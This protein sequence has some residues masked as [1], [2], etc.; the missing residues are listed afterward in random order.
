MLG[1]AKPGRRF[2]TFPQPCARLSLNQRILHFSLLDDTCSIL[3][4]M[5]PPKITS[6]LVAK[7]AIRVATRIVTLT[8]WSEGWGFFLRFFV[9]R[10][11]LSIFL[12]IASYSI[13]MVL[14]FF[15]RSKLS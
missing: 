8:I 10:Y 7:P 11:K 9:S 4:T 13:R 3:V 5:K 12:T 6:I 2:H 1:G 14:E 15:S